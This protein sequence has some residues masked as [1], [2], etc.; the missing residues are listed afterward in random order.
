LV[1]KADR[2]ASVVQSGAVADYHRHPLRPHCDGLAAGY[3]QR[4][5]K[6][7]NLYHYA[8]KTQAVRRLSEE[9]DEQLVPATDKVEFTTQR[10]F[11]SVFL[12]QTKEP[13]PA[14]LRD[15]TGC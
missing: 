6:Y 14:E 15:L 2:P 4:V 8:R 11:R 5:T 12:H 7:I 1:A 13:V 9:F 10:D 3:R